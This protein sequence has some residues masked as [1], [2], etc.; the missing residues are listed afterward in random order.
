[1]K[2]IP[3]ILVITVIL[4]A[5]EKDMPV[6]ITPNENRTTESFYTWHDV[7]SLLASPFEKYDKIEVIPATQSFYFSGDE[8]DINQIN[9]MDEETVW[10][11]PFEAEASKSLVAANMKVLHNGEGNLEEG[12]YIFDI[13]L[14]G[15]EIDLPPNTVGTADHPEPVGYMNVSDQKRGITY[16]M[17]SSPD[18]NR[19]IINT[20]VIQAK[21]RLSG[22]LVD[23]MLP[24]PISDNI[25]YIYYYTEIG[26]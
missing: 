6:S 7:H 21:N 17:N 5:C 14:F 11:G 10:E 8:A 26:S 4:F 20:Y 9:H 3:S 22:A 15:A 13:F 16:H 24:E 2:K 12:I 23:Q 1:M 18:G 25:S 19:F